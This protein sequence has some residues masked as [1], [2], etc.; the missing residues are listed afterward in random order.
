MDDNPYQT[1]L[2]AMEPTTA[3]PEGLVLGKVISASPL[4]VLVGGNTQEGADLL[5]NAD[6]MADTETDITAQLAGTGSISGASSISG[7]ADFALSGK[8]SRSNPFKAGDR[9]LLLPIE[10][11]QRYIIICKVVD[12]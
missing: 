1:I 12:V 11:K 3:A 8:I 4:R 7:T 9:L 6:L 5:C 10:A 2:T